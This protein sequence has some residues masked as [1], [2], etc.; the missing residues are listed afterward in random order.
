MIF[1]AES[2]YGLIDFSDKHG[3]T[4]YYSKNVTS[5]DAEKIKDILIKRGIKSENNRLT[6]QSEHEYTVKIAAVEHKEETIVEGDL[7]IKLVYGEFGP[8]LRLVNRYLAEC[9][10]Y[11]ANEIQSKMIHEYI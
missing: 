5:S 9:Q 6:K 3:T 2:P 7:K 8:F 4:G 1:N 11:S 10:K